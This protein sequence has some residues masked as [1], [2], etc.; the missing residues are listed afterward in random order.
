MSP[1]IGTTTTTTTATP[2]RR[3][4]TNAICYCCDRVEKWTDGTRARTLPWRPLLRRCRLLAGDRRRALQTQQQVC[5]TSYIGTRASERGDQSV[6]NGSSRC[7]YLV[8][9][10]CRRSRHSCVW[11]FVSLFFF[12][13]CY[14]YKLISRD[15]SSPR[16]NITHPIFGHGKPFVCVFPFVSPLDCRRIL[17][18]SPAQVHPGLTLQ[19]SPT[20]CSVR[21][22][23]VLFR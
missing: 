19:S 12:F 7:T 10:Q 18:F 5:Y 9:L 2:R 20:V 3:R 11:Y 15:R 16:A 13:F 1:I 22:R 14:A 23:N 6:S 4:A 21:D 8:V 17:S